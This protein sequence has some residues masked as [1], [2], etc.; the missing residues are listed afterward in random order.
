MLLSSANTLSFEQKTYV[1]MFPL[2]MLSV[3]SLYPTGVGSY[4]GTIAALISASIIVLN[5]ARFRV[6]LVYL[7]YGYVALHSP[8]A[9]PMVMLDI[10]LFILLALLVLYKDW[11]M[12]MHNIL[13]AAMNLLLVVAYLSAVH[14]HQYGTPFTVSIGN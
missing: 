2:L 5:H 9:N 10:E 1:V 13:A 7:M 6:L 12:V 8:Q 14:W 3:A 11:L 4:Q